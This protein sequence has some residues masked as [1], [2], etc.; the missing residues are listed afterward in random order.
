MEVGVYENKAL[1]E[2]VYR[3]KVMC[4][5]MIFDIVVNAQDIVGHVVAGMRF[6]GIVWLQGKVVK[7]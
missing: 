2:K 4:N 5:N 3:L 7:K 6:R 1:K